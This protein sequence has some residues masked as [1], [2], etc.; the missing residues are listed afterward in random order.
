[1][2][3]EW[4]IFVAE[5]SVLGG[6][7]PFIAGVAVVAML[8]GA[9]WLDTRR[10]ARAPRRPLPEEQ[11][12]LPEGGPVHEEL[13]NRE[14]DEIPKS[15]LRLLPYQVHGNL[16][17]RPSPEKKRPRWSKGGSGSFGSGG[18]GAH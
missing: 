5:R 9:V 8:V 17:S 16:G 3:M 18:L 6:I 1:M 11:P 7:A 10:R 13:E 15:D 12:H 14:P 2:S 4:A